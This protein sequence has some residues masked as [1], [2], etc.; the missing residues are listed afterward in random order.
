MTGLVDGLV[1]TTGLHLKK[2]T[3]QWS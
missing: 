3:K 1:E 2:E